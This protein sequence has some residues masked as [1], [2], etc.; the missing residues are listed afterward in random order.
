MQLHS[1]MICPFCLADE[2][3]A[4]AIDKHG[5]PYLSCGACGTR[6]LTK[7]IRALNGLALMRPALERAVRS[8]RGN[9]N[10]FDDGMRII[11]G[12]LAP[13]SARAP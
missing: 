9:A 13:Q 6:V 4:L 8:M 2:A 11:G 1:P 12:E 3:A 10:A 5:N 7:S